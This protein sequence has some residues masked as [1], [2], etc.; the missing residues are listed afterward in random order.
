MLSRSDK[1]ISA[2]EAISEFEQ[3]IARQEDLIYGVALF[4]ECLNIL[5]AD[6]G[7]VVETHRKQFRNVIQKG[8]E[9][10]RQAT[11]LL[12]DVRMN[13]AKVELLKQFVFAPCQGH[14]NPPEMARRAAILVE[15]C[16]RIFPG[17]PRSDE[18]SS[19][20]TLKLIE[21]ASVVFKQ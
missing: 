18:F 7:A 16:G 19:E 2:E 20:E 3:E 15:A 14:P 1:S 4:F 13:P 5:H 21:E 12:E 11:M 8:K 17:R 10:T 6:Q 9:A